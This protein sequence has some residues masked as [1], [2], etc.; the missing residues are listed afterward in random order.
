M[1]PPPRTRIM[2]PRPAILA[3]RPRGHA[4]NQE[5]LHSYTPSVV[6]TGSRAI[7]T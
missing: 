5:L 3:T 4:A 2:P 7:S 6:S 1:T